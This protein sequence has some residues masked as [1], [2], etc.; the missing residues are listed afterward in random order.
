MLAG[1]HEFKVVDRVV[2]AVVVFVVDVVSFW[3]KAVVMLP[4]NSVQIRTARAVTR[5]VVAAGLAVI[6]NTVELW[7][8]VLALVHMFSPEV[9]SSIV[10]YFS[11]SARTFLFPI[12]N[13]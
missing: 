1:R 5:F 11:A 4:N 13:G 10:A 7:D 6:S 8:W 3:N 2:V 9:L 12:K